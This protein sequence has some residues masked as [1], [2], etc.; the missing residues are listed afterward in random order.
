[1]KVKMVCDRDNET[2]EVELP[3]DE[4]KLLEI[5]GRVLDRNT[6]GYIVG[7]DVNYYDE[8]GN[9]IDNIFLLNRQLQS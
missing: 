2:R 3:I 7:A 8:S 4:N 9:K 6:L 5:Q 1:M